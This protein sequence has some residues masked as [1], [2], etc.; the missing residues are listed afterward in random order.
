MFLLNISIVIITLVSDLHASVEF[1][2]NYQNRS[3][4]CN[5]IVWLRN[6]LATR[7]DN[8]PTVRKLPQNPNHRITKILLINEQ[9]D[10]VHLVMQNT[11]L[12]IVGFIANGIF[13]RFKDH[14]DVNVEGVE[15]TVDISLQSNYQDLARAADRSLEDFEVNKEKMDHSITTLSHH[16]NEGGPSL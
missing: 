16:G 10:V 9:S 6:R 2:F 1:E 8:I 3:E 15:F 5:S 12:Y 7:A 4:Y 13:F 14:S 11:N